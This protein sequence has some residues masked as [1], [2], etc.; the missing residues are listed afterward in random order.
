MQKIQFYYNKR[1]VYQTTIIS[2][3]L[4]LVFLYKTTNVTKSGDILFYSLL[5]LGFLLLA[6]SFTKKYFFQTLKSNVAIELNEN[7]IMDYGETRIIKW[8]EI[9]NIVPVRQFLFNKYSGI[10]IDLYDKNGYYNS[11]TPAKKVNAFVT[12]ML[13]KT[14]IVIHLKIIAYDSEEIVMTFQDYF[15]K[16]KNSS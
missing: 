3:F 1:V 11:L 7:A 15:K 6:F 8:E 5:S 16:I 9:E 10:A 13:Y 4:F 2:A 12:K 14:P